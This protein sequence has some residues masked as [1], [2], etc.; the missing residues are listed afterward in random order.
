MAEKL[1]T[2][3]FLEIEDIREGVLLLKNK[4]LRGVMMVSSINF[5]LMSETEQEGVIY[6]FQEFLNTLDFSCQIVVQ[7]RKLNMTSYLDKLKQLELKQKEELLKAQT[8]EYRNFIKNLVEK[9]NI[10]TKTFFLVVPYRLSELLGVKVLKRGG[11]FQFTTRTEEKTELT[12]EEFQRCK[13]QLWSRMEY[14]AVGLRRCGL[15]AV[16]L[17]NKELIEL[18]WSW[19]HPEEAEVGY[20]P[21]ILPELLK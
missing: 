13:S 2:Q 17:N 18:F 3:D 9:T 16:P 8:R 7:S 4:E 10:M 14:V 1:S 21:E 20:Y 12:D 19:H 5:A 11:I 15:R 6:A